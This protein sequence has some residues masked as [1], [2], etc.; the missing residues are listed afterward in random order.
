MKEEKKQKRKCYNC[1]FAG[2]QFKIVGKTHLHCYNKEIF[3]EKDF[4]NGKLSAWDTLREWWW[5]CEKHEFK[6]T[7]NKTL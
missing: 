1:Q 7:N 3:P 6:V 4:E 2:K 5:G